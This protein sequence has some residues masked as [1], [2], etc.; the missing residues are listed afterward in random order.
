MK[1]V[2][3]L[4]M[5]LT[6][7]AFACKS[8]KEVVKEEPKPDNVR[9]EIVTP[10]QV[11]SDKDHFRAANMATSADLSLSKEKALL[12]AKQRLASLINTQIKAVTDR[13]V[14]EREFGQGSEFEQKFENLTREVVD[15]RL[16][17]VNIICEKSYQT[18]EGKY[19]TY[20]AIEVNKDALLNGIENGISQDKKLQIDYDKMKFQ[21][22]FNEEMDKLAKERGQ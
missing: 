20:I 13:Y 18:Q 17:E 1:R 15:Q 6:I 22:I 21:Q 11:N 10:C 5:V 3:F 9:K 14:N 7:I 2:S 16:S 4:L 12:L 19:Q 8:K